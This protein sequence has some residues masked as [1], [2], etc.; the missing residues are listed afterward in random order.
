MR[1]RIA[2]VLVL[3][4][5]LVPQASARP[6]AAEMLA[7]AASS[8]MAPYAFYIS[9]TR[10]VPAGSSAALEAA[11][12]SLRGVENAHVSQSVGADE[13]VIAV[14]IVCPP[15]ESK[16]NEAV[17]RIY[18]ALGRQAEII[19]CLTGRAS[20][21]QADDWTLLPTRMLAAL[22]DVALEGAQ[23]VGFVSHTG[24]WAQAAVRRNGDAYLGVPIIPLDY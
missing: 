10:R 3:L 13:A 12:R 5:W 1:W 24:E 16:V 4:C 23:T 11:E 19:V 6:D 14:A 15:E 8:G 22:S 7:A 21:E 2:A 18:S 17:R 9:A 20:G